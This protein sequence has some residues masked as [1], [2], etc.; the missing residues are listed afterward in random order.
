MSVFALL[1]GVK[2]DA[3]YLHVVFR[4]DAFL[5]QVGGKVQ[6]HL[7]AQVRKQRVRAL[8]GD[9][10]FQGLDVQWLDVGVI[11]HIG[12]GHDGGGIGVHQDDLVT[13]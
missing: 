12:V 6:G 10:L 1:D 9:D 13:K 11:G 8:L 4:Q 3:Y 2:L 7:P 5:G